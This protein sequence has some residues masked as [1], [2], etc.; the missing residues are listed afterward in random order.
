MKRK[1]PKSVDAYIASFPKEVQ[2]RLKRI[3]ATIRKAAP[4]AEEK[5]SYGIP[6]YIASGPVIYFAGFAKH[7]SVYPAPRSA[8][9]FKDELARYRGG[10]GTVQFPLDEKIPLGLVTRMVKF[11]LRQST[12]GSRQ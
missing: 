12:V 10:K 11:R 5:I 1:T 9:E 2:A 3:R 8:P 7:I 4:K 6:A